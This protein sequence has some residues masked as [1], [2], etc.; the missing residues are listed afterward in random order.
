MDLWQWHA[1]CLGGVGAGRQREVKKNPPPYLIVAT[2][3]SSGMQ[4]KSDYNGG[5]W[6][7]LQEG[8]LGGV[9]CVL[10]DKRRP[11]CVLESI[12]AQCPRT[13]GR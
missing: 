8:V 2:K 10:G 12:G 1:W 3:R 11:T 6:P 9:S 5:R 13:G 4:L 7:W